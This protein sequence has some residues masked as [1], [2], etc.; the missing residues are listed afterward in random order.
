[1][2]LFGPAPVAIHDDGDVGRQHG[3]GQRTEM[4]DV[5]AHGL[6]GC[7][8]QFGVLAR[9]GTSRPAVL[10][11]RRSAA[12]TAFFARTPRGLAASQSGVALRLPPHSKGFATFDAQNR[13]P[14]SW[15][16]PAERSGDRVFRP[17]TPRPGRIPK[18]SRAPLATALQRLRQVRRAEPRASVL[19]C[20]GRAQ[21][22]RRFLDRTPRGSAAP[23]SS[24][25]L[26]LPHSQTPP[27]RHRKMVCSRAGPTEAIANLAPVNSAMALR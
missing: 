23:Q 2:A 25:A 5:R 19:E 4:R 22:R 1:M 17:Q 11:S 12:P 26:R 8:L 20:A 27:V 24:V 9:K 10:F 15:S 21:R 13:A 3:P 18:R 14:A 7:T 16:A 6:I